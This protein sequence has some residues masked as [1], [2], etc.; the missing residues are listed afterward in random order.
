[1]TRGLR[2][3]QWVALVATIGSLVIGGVGSI[4]LRQEARVV[5]V[6]D[7]L[8][9]F[10]ASSGATSESQAGDQPATDAAPSEQPDG[11]ATA[12]AAAASG[13]AQTATAVGT[14]TTVAR[15]QSTPSA[16]APAPG[17]QAPASQPRP[18]DTAEGVYVYATSG[19]ES[20]NALGGS[21]H[22]YPK[23]TAMTLHRSDCGVVQRWQPLNERWDES[24]LCIEKD[25]VAIR[26]FTTYHE[27][28]QRGQKQDFMCPPSS[29]VARFAVAT[30]TTWTW[31]CKTD[32]GAIDTKVTFV[33]FEEFTVEG[34]ARRAAHFLYESTMTGSNRGT[35]RQER[36]IDMEFTLNLKIQTDIDTEA[37]SPFGAVH[38]EEK[39]TVTLTSLTPKR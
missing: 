8:A 5:T 38:Y 30:G 1:M 33:G 31:Q 2:R 7:A 24:D 14:P 27:F 9:N 18:Q 39:Y 19:Y 21:R 17:A 32:S 29:H 11:A 4:Y 15:A 25:A 35:Q 6:D 28:F 16:P 36:W 3:W 26:R 10:R 34:K 37:D 23:E 20:T 13:P 12:G 22:D